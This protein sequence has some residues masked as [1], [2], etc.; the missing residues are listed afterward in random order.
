MATRCGGTLC[1]GGPARM[2]RRQKEPFG[3]V[4]ISY[5]CDD[6]LVE[7]CVANLAIAGIVQRREHNGSRE[8]VV[9]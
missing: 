9:Q 5:T 4:D 1:D 2:D 8:I 7:D 6:P 3:F